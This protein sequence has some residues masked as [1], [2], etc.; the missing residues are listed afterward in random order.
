MELL[1]GLKISQVMA[2][3]L[4]YCRPAMEQTSMFQY[5]FLQG[6]PCTLRT[7]L[8]EQEPDDIRSLAARVDW[9]CVSHKQQAST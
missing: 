4:T 7:M 5:M 1:G 8:V 6:L 2:S 9:L 3:M